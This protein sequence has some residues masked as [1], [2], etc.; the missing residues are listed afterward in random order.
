MWLVDL[1]GDFVNIF[2]SI[3]KWKIPWLYG[4]EFGRGAAP[5]Y[6]DAICEKNDAQYCDQ[7]IIEW[8][9]ILWCKSLTFGATLVGRITQAARTCLGCVRSMLSE[10]FDH[11]TIESLVEFITVCNRPRILKPKMFLQ[12][13]SNLAEVLA[14]FKIH[15]RYERHLNR[16]S[17]SL[18]QTYEG[19]W[20]GSFGVQINLQ[21]DFVSSPC[22]SIQ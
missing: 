4:K 11:R 5:A 9:P 2:S 13:R 15:K 22:C 10:R 7:H 8:S 18:L 3:D 1:T 6:P 16:Q 12:W 21:V 20:N 19:D 14:E 17:Q